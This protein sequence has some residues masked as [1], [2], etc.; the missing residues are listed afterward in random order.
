[1]TTRA[2]KFFRAGGFDQVNLVSGDDLLHLGDLDQK[3]WVALAC[4]TQGIEFDPRTLELLDSDHD[5]R[6]RAPELIAACRWVG[7]L[8]HSPDALLTG[9]AELPL[10]A[11]GDG[12]EARR[13]LA[14]AKSV[15]ASLGK[16]TASALSVDDASDA[17]KVFSQLKFN[18]DGVVPVES[19][20]DEAT[21]RVVQELIDCL[22]GE[23]D[24]GGKAGMTA[25]KVERFFK[26]LEAH[27]AWLAQ[28]EADPALQPFR[29]DTP[30]AHQVYAAVKSKIDDYFARCRLAAFDPRALP[31]LNRDEKEYQA[32]AAKDMSLAA[33]ELAAFPLSHVEVN[34]ALPLLTGL[35]PAWV[36]AIESLSLKVVRPLLG[37]MTELTEAEWY[38]IGHTFAPYERWQTAKAGPDVEKLGAA[39]VKELVQ[40]DAKAKLEALLVRE[41]EQDPIAKSL[42]DVERLVRYHRDLYRL[43]NNFVSFRDFYQR[44][45]P[46]VFQVGT[47]YLD[48]RACELCVRVDDA[49]RHAAMAPL[50]RTALAYCDVSRPASGEKMS[51]AAAFTAGDSDT[52]M[53]GRNGIFYDRQGRDW[54]ATVTKVVDAPISV[55][56]AFWSPY[57]KAIRFIEAE[58][59]KRALAADEASTERLGGVAT[60]LA[61]PPNAGAA[62]GA[63]KTLDV[64][65][66]AA[67]GVAVG[68]LTAALGALLSA[69]FGLG[70]L[71]PLGVV[72]LLLAISGPS[73]LIA[74]LKLR[75]RTLGPLLDANG[76]ALNAPARINVAF[77]GSLTRLAVLPPGSKRDLRDPFVD[78]AR[79][80]GLWLALLALLALAGTWY[81]GKLDAL[82]PLPARSVEVLGDLAPAYRAPARGPLPLP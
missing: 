10:G 49:G 82:L 60:E 53:V 16:A 45:A 23:Q 37:G 75:Q 51:I 38:E 17:V 44:R 29:A 31:A 46:A 69:F 39:R 78:K 64:G 25:A 34:R 63:R 42:T 30:Q 70:W 14:T 32:V 61:K 57:K 27:A 33:T 15:L 4:P 48:Q 76:W 77:G 62:A 74:W 81:L 65:T 19:V 9:A 18:G 7:S 54:D 79:P 2:W 40:G 36:S 66:V 3:L 73:M 67:L 58:I 71:M 55:R 12:E 52:L 24:R 8:L 6:I 50:T 26:E 20:D 68:G 1:V 21:R 72:A 5:R 22:G 43:A 59:A 28:A 56:Q 80:W 11:I 41:K 13:L 35:N 47:L